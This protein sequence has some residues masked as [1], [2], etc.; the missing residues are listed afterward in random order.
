MRIALVVPGGV[1]RSGR[2]RVVPVL[3]WLVERLARRH[4][5][6]VVVLDYYAE[7]CTYPLLGATVHDVGRVTGPPGFRRVRLA[8][9]LSEVMA[10]IGAVD[11]VHAYWGMPAGVVAVPIARRLGVPI[12]V[13]LSSG[14]LVRHANIR[15]GLQRRWIDRRAIAHTVKHATAITVPT[16][17]MARLLT[18]HAGP[19]PAARAQAMDATVIPMGIDTTQF[20][21]GHR[22]EGPPW[23]LI[24]VGSVNA[25]KDIPTLLHAM[26][27]LPPDVALD[28]VGEDTLG[29]AM[30][31]LTS[32]LGIERRVTFHGWQPTDRIAGLF[33]AAHLNIVS[34][35]HEASNVTML[36][37]ACAGVPTVGTAVGYVA[38]WHPDRAVA[39]PVGD[40]RALAD[41]ITALLHDSARRTMLADAARRWTLAHD[42]D[43]TA[44]AFE[45]LFTRIIRG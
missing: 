30:Q 20:A 2:E 40:P 22:S 45:S 14:E 35:I 3:L 33:G 18:E 37:A 39:V 15:Y 28:I 6:H 31:L 41:A 4:D 8:K 32:Q 34:S 24:R 12:V 23:R 9:R 7:P 13:T 26:A 19:A 11:I 43:W 38:D 27:A 1:D 36:E 17:Y 42:A 25:V 44:S 10:R 16:A 21:V 29:G 5:V